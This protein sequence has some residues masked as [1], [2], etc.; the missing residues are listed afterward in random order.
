L[1]FVAGIDLMRDCLAA[2][3]ADR[4][5]GLLSGGKMAIGDEDVCALFCE[6]DRGGATRFRWRCP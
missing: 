2:E 5:G 1:L 3:L 6:S 4:G